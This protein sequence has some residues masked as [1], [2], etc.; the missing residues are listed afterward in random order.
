MI[1]SDNGVG[2]PKNLDLQKTKTLGLQLVNNL[3]DQLEASIEVV[4]NSGTEFR[5][6]FAI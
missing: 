6:I 4:S 3:V 2:L 5:I 1:V